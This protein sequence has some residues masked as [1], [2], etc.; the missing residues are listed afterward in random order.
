MLMMLLKL[1]I[2]LLLFF[3]GIEIFTEKSKSKTKLTTKSRTLNAERKMFWKKE[4]KL[5]NSTKI[6]LKLKN[7]QKINKFILK[8]KQSI[9]VLPFSR[10]LQTKLYGI[11][12][13]LRKNSW[14]FPF[15]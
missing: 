10:H 2:S 4:T 8:A 5:R 12:K 13:I 1:Y 3:I 11:D 14:N 9:N 15:K 7:A 6:A